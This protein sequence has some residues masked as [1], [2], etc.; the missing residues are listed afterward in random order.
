M[1]FQIPSPGL[2][3]QQQLSNATLFRQLQL[4]LAE[5]K[6]AG[7]ERQ[8]LESQLA[9]VA[10]RL[11]TMTQEKLEVQRACYAANQDKARVENL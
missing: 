11:A 6:S 1:K 9:V 2:L 10:N 4:A 5:I 7:Q 8:K 3:Q